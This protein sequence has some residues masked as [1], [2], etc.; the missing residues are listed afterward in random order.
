M[1][2]EPE[3]SIGTPPAAPVAETRR[4]TLLDA[5]RGLSILGIAVVN[6]QFF[7]SSYMTLPDWRWNQIPLSEGIVRA[8]VVFFAEHHFFS[9][10]SILFGMGLALQYRRMQEAM[11]SFGG[12]YFRR[13]VVLLVFGIAHAI[14]L[15]YGDILA[16]YALV[17][18]VVYWFRNASTKTLLGSA[19]VIFMVPVIIQSSLAMM[20]PSMPGQSMIEA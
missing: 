3:S 5:L 8:A 11:E 20:N 4:I 7:A 6:V 2:T 19:I 1:N 18:I 13:L 10:F 17:G 12:L 9:I 15:W 14:L 16:L